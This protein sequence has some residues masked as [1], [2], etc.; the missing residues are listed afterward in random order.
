MYLGKLVE[1]RKTSTLFTQPK[2]PYTEALMSAVALPTPSCVKDV[3]TFCG[4]EIRNAPIAI[5]LYFL[6]AIVRIVVLP[7]RPF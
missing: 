1:F 6:V 5:G 7:K 4:G 3:S 2:H